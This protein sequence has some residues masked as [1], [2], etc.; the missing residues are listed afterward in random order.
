MSAL[1]YGLVRQDQC[2]RVP[3]PNLFERAN[4]VWHLIE[5]QSKG[6]FVTLEGEPEDRHWS[7]ALNIA[8]AHRIQS[9]H[10]EA[11]LSDP[12]KARRVY[13]RDLCNFVFRGDDLAAV[14]LTRSISPARV[15]VELRAVAPKYRKESRR[16][17]AQVILRPLSKALLQNIEC[18][19]LIARS[20]EEAE[21]IALARR[22]GG[23]RFQYRHIFEWP[24]TAD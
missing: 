11:H 10:M 4:A 20:P 18:L 13:R 22:S 2:W 9:P 15:F 8:R 16:L 24:V 1:G 3:I 23:V 6:D 19:E 21:T 12:A 17:N 14:V 7:E 5:Q